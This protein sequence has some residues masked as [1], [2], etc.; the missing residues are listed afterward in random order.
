LGRGA[1]LLLFEFAFEAKG[2]S[3]VFAI[4]D[5]GHQASW[6]LV[7]AFDFAEVE[8]QVNSSGQT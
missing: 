8:R 2:A 6:L 1:S 5:P 3:S 7:N 4:V